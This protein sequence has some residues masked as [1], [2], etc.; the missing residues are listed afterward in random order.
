MCIR[1][2]LQGLETV[3]VD[4]REMRKEVFAAII[5]RN[6]TETLGIIEPLNSTDCHA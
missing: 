4:R 3:H 5:R 2:S 1:D 6:E